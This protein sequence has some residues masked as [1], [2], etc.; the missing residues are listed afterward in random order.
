[1]AFTLLDLP[2]ELLAHIAQDLSNREDLIGLL[3]L[4]KSCKRLRTLDCSAFQP[5]LAIRAQLFSD[6]VVPP[7][8]RRQKAAELQLC[9][10]L[11]SPC[12]RGGRRQVVKNAISKLDSEIGH[13]YRALRKYELWESRKWVHTWK[14]MVQCCSAEHWQRQDRTDV[15]QALQEHL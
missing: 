6:T 3:C 13:C 12:H 10:L 7:I 2:D 15:R 14:H 1:M 8:L 9:L 5:P 11:L 4:R